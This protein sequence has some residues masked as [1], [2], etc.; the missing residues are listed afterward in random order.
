MP[1]FPAYLNKLLQVR[2][3]AQTL[4]GLQPVAACMG[5]QLS[6]RLA[7]IVAPAL[8]LRMLLLSGGHAGPLPMDLSN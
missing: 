2:L 1:L 8:L 6:V 5:Q 4:Q 7:A 3:A